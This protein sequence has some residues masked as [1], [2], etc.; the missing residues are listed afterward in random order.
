MNKLLIFLIAFMLFGFIIKA[1]VNLKNGLVAYYPFNGNANDESGNSNN[2]I[3]NGATLTTDRFGNINSAFS[4]NG[5]NNYIN[6]GNGNS[7]NIGTKDFSI[8][9]WFKTKEHSTS[10]LEHPHSGI[11]LYKGSWWSEIGYSLYMRGSEYGSIGGHLGVEV[12][13]GPIGTVI[14]RTDNEID[15]YNDGVWHNLIFIAERIK[16]G[17]VYV[18]GKLYFAGDIS[19][20]N[21]SL[22]NTTPLTIGG[23]LSN[24][25]SWHG[26]L[27]DFRIFNRVLNEQEIQAL[28]NENIL[29]LS[30]DN[31]T[32]NFEQWITIPI[33]TLNLNS[34]DNVL[35]YKFD[36]NYDNTK[37]Q[38]V[39]NSLLGTW[40]DN[41]S[42]QVNQSTGK[43]SI[44]WARQTPITGTG[45]GAIL[46]LLFKALTIGTTTPTITNAMFNTYYITKV[47]N[48]TITIIENTGSSSSS[49]GVGISRDGSSP[50]VNA[51]LDVK[52]TDK[53]ILIPRIDFSNRPISNLTSGLLVFVIANG[54][55]GN[56]AFYYYDGIDWVKLA[57]SSK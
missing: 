25:R 54:P 33:N 30:T 11:V 19:V 40:A 55:Q 44:A 13:S 22:E 50:D 53:G 43:L 8:S 31:Q 16:L 41:A 24:D 21:G 28:Y 3:V 20:D 56:N 39:S 9:I 36:Y 49:G 57:I 34:T 26:L 4:F 37:L 7:I 14:E 6:L 17:K 1:Q 29:S 48:G 2:G 18:D 15:K 45:T 23:Q 47:T 10:A 52:A 5:V 42:L 35:S 27:D 12:A 51:I 32:I 46:K 38:Y